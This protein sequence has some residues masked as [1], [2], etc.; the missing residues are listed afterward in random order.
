MHS[1]FSPTTSSGDAKLDVDTLPGNDRPSRARRARMPLIV[2][3]IAIIVLYHVFHSVFVPGCTARST[4]LSFGHLNTQSVCPQEDVL[5]PTKNSDMWSRTNELYSTQSFRSRAVRRLGEAVKIPTETFDAMA[6]VGED[7]RWETRQPFVDHLAMEY[8]YTHKYL[9]LQKVNTYGLIYTWKGTDESLKPLL[10]MGHYDVVPVAPLSVD[11][12]TFPPYSGHFDGENVWGR[13]SSDDKS[14]VIGIMTTVETLLELGFKPTRTIVLSFGFDEEAGGYHGAGHL[15]PALLERFGP[16]SMAMIVDEGSGFSESHGAIFAAPGIGE[17]GSVNVQ[18]DIQTPGGHS[19]VPPEHTSIGML[20]ALIVHLEN[21]APVPKLTPNTPA[22]L[23]TQCLAAHAP[24]M[25]YSAKHA[26]LHADK[27]KKAMKIAEKFLFQ[28]GMIKALVGTT[29]AVD[30]IHGGVKSNALPEQASAIVNHRIATQSSVK[31]TIDRDAQL[32]KALAA[33]FNL[34]VTA[35]GE[36]LTPLG[37]PAY[38]TLELTA[39]Q[40]LEPAPIAPSDAKPFKLLAG[41]IRAVFKTARADT[42]DKDK[43]I[44]VMPGIMSGNTD[45]RFNWELSDHIFRYGHGNM[46]IGGLNGIHTVNEHISAASFL[47]MITFFTTL[48][49]NVDEAQL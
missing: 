9:E 1:F 32:V 10:L 43:E 15:G 41:T 42:L 4:P 2:G 3:G 36:H 34:S 31:E 16:D 14:G 38:G 39:P 40:T 26:I 8:P 46:V 6:P 22:F 18:V 28:D 11:Q 17:K 20:A 44:F 23:M 24:S 29:Q 45:T 5:T 12:W 48:I 35:Y 13:G 7:S 30:I 27:S 21:N 49:L 25:P 37:A 47:E 33:E 19:S